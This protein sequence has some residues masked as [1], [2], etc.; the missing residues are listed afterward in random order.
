M[1]FLSENTPTGKKI[2]NLLGLSHLNQSIVLRI[3]I[4]TL[5]VVFTVLMFPHGESIEFNYAVGSV[6]TESDLIAPF[7]YAIHK[8]IRLYE[9]ELREAAH[10]VYPVFERDETITRRQID[11]LSVL[12]KT[13]K[14]IFDLRPKLSKTVSQKFDQVMRQTLT[15]VLRTGIINQQKQRQVHGPIALRNG[16]RETI[17]PLGKVYDLDGAETELRSELNGVFGENEL[18][19]AGMELFHRVL[20]PNIILNET[21]TNRAIQLAEENVPRT[22]GYV[23]E[24]D[25]VISKGDRITEENKLRLE[26]Y[27]KAKIDHGAN[28][29]EWRHYAGIIL[30]TALVIG[31]FALYLFLFRKKIFYDNTKLGLIALLVLMEMLFAYG[32]VQLNLTGP[33]QFLIFVPAASMLLTIIFDSRVAFYGTVTVAFLIAAIRGNDYGL[34]LISLITGAI[35]AYTVRDI[36]HRTQ[37]FRSLIFIFLAYAVSILAL[38][39]ERFESGPVILTNL[40]FAF[41]N[42]VISPLLTYGLLIFFERSFNVTTDLTLLELADLNR[43]LLQELSEKAPGTFH[44]SMTIGNLAE[45]GAEAIGANAILSRVGGYYHDIGKMLKPEYFV[46]NQ[47]GVHNKHNRLK[48]RMSALIIASHVKDGV[49][50]GRQHGLPENVLDF[51]PQHH[52]TNRISFF[53]DKALKQAAKKPPK[54]TINEEDF[55]YPGPK[56]QSKETGIV[57]LADSVEA[58]TRALTDLTQHRL[59]QSIDNMIKHRFLEGQLDECELTLRDLTNIKEAFL[60]ILTGIHHH[61]IKY[62][63]QEASEPSQPESVEV[64]PQTENPVPKIE[65]QAEIPQ[66]QDVTATA[67]SVPAITDTQAKEQPNDGQSPVIPETT[68]GPA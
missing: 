34:A 32:S 56:P 35:G 4:G 67:Q 22:I 54:D 50:L 21:E 61:R 59:E 38:S 26:S 63:E 66:A 39:I 53:Y 47:V 1:A 55:R 10:A 44:H 49:E 20:G 58:S 12:L 45:A 24:N 46:E 17:I 36:R 29:D 15:D 23:Q 65:I 25:R 51:I 40:M 5:L 52:G 57:M 30:H 8:E 33:I 27:Q 37:I 6:W 31:L 68:S 13:S 48:P 60:K 14:S 3:V 19:N 43:P 41:A 28:F 11:S 9:K 64:V 16:V 62:P 7:S 2:A 42:A 18:S